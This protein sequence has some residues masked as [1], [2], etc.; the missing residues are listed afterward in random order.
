MLILFITI[1][2]N[3]EE[4][5]ALSKARQELV[6]VPNPRA[7]PQASETGNLSRQEL[8]LGKVIAKVTLQTKAPSPARDNQNKKHT[9]E[10]EHTPHYQ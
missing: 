9:P 5:D 6:G 2:L 7:L 1:S 3:K 4:G 8:T 10:N